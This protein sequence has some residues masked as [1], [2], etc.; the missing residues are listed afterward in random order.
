MGGL[1]DN[2]GRDLIALGTGVVLSIRDG[3]EVRADGRVLVNDDGKISG[4]FEVLCLGV[5]EVAGCNEDA[6]ELV[7]ADQDAIIVAS[8]F[9]AKVRAMR[10]RIG[11]DFTCRSQPCTLEP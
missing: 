5:E 9:A 1:S 3:A 11:M 7:A 4:N 6:W 8:E 2:A 10:V